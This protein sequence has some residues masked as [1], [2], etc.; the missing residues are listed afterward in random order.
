MTEWWAGYSAGALVVWCGM[1]L[2]W[3]AERRRNRSLQSYLDRK[4]PK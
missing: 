2:L 1:F 3:L 4:R